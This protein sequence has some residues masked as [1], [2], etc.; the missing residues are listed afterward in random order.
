MIIKTVESAAAKLSLK[1][2]FKLF[3][4]YYFV[5]KN[6]E[7]VNFLRNTLI[8]SYG[9]RVNND[10]YVFD[11]D[12]NCY[13]TPIIKDIQSIGRAH[14]TIFFLDQYGYSEVSIKAL[15]YIF[16]MLPKSEVILTF[17]VDSLIDYL[18]NTP[19]CQKILNGIDLFYDLEKLHDEKKQKKWRENIQ[20]ALYS[21]FKKKINAKYMTNF[22]IKSS[23]SSRSYWLLHLS[24]NPR[25][26]DEMQKLHWDFKNHFV[27]ETKTGLKI[28][29]AYDPMKDFNYT[30][31]HSIVFSENDKKDN[32]IKL[33]SE[34]PENLTFKQT[35][36]KSFFLSNIN[37]TPA[38]QRMIYDAIQI[39]YEN[40][41]LDVRSKSGQKKRKGVS[42]NDT[43]LVSISSQITLF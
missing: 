31:Q 38:T 10:I 24:M 26:R 9:G 4:R 15:N 42:I 35:P 2:D 37:E 34:I 6:K 36:V 14:R 20:I 8:D 12:F 30:K 33:L 7:T 16:N 41:E 18:S 13:L 27:S 40:N 25:A 1:K 23:E 19:E 32:K 17:N 29:P 5:E 22:F 21:D 11:G 3:A 39:L 28:F 43:D